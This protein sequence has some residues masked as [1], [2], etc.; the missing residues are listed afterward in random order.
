[1][2]RKFTL[3][4]MNQPK[5]VMNQIDIEVQTAGFHSVEIDNPKNKNNQQNLLHHRN[6]NNV[7][8]CYTTRLLKR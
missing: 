3:L 8:I 2:D 1:M 5:S 6:M 4:E 7:F